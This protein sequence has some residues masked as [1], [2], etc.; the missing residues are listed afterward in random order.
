MRLLLAFFCLL[1]GLA[2]GAADLTLD[3]G[4]EES[5]G[6]LRVTPIVTSATDRRLRYEVLA[7]KEGASG[8]SQSR[9][10][11]NLAVRAGV[12]ASASTLALGIAPGD[13]YT[14]TVR[15]FEGR[16]LLAEKKLQ[17]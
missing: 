15:L 8:K 12:R 17:K 6:Q 16:K 7:Q 10:A 11:G 2:A 4:A 3:I 14:V 9:Q 1:V 13:R 5:Q